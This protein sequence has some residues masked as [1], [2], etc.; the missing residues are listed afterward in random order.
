MVTKGDSKIFTILLADDGSE[1]SRSAVHLLG[2][3]SFPET[4][5]VHVLRVITPLQAA[6]H[7]SFENSLEE[8]RAAISAIGL[9]ARSELL[10]GYPAEKIIETSEQ[11][12]PDLI[13]M[14]A[15]GL[16]STLGILLGGVAQQVVEYACCPVMIVRAPYVDLSRILIAS[17]G[18]D[19]SKAAIRF[20]GTL[21]R[22]KNI[23]IDVIHVLPPPPIPMTVIEP[24]FVDLSI[25]QPWEITEEEAERRK[26]EEEE[27]EELLQTIKES[28]DKFGYEANT[29][30]KRGDAASEINEYVKTNEVKLIVTGSRGLGNIRSWLMGSVSRKLVHYSNCSVLV[31]RGDQ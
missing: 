29:V 18:S 2:G 9:D 7:E 28:L 31:V 14:G 23:D 20:F 25:N 11:L 22:I 13:V 5:T 6:E 21:P 17:D 24:M 15:K 8:T 26:K 19:S 3:L 1:H 4:T 10:L 16:R 30:L 12:C 27:G